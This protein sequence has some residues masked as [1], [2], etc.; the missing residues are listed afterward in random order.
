M[1][2]SPLVSPF[3]ACEI[4]AM[5]PEGDVVRDFDTG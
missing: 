3:W 4:L 5:Q 2:M 1:Q